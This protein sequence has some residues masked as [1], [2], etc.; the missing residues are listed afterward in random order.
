MDSKTTARSRSNTLLDIP[1][2]Q[3]ESFSACYGTENISKMWEA[4][5][6]GLRC[7]MGLLFLEE[8]YSRQQSMNNSAQGK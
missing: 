6:V 8:M 2:I 3:N 4:D 1:A 7:N 5:I